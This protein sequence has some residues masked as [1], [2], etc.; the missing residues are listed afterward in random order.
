[1][2]CALLDGSD[3]DSGTAAE[4]GFAHALGRSVFGLCTDGY[5]RRK[6][7][8]NVIWGICANGA[9]IHSSIGDLV[10]DVARVLATVG[11]FKIHADSKQSLD[12]DVKNAQQQSL[13]ESSSAA[14]VF[15]QSRVPME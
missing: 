7:M 10:F 4:M 3:V 13:G 9:R 1:M 15:P 6:T 2:V 12:R 14:Q 11:D 5:R 8:N